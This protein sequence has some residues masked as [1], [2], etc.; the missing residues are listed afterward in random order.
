MENLTAPA[1]PGND[2][3]TNA[4]F[5]AE[6]ELTEKQ[7]SVLGT[8]F[9]SIFIEGP[10]DFIGGIFGFFRRY[11]R[12]YGES[13]RFFKRPSLKVAPFE[14]ND[15]KENAMQSFELALIFTAALIFMIKQSWIPVNNDLQE[16]YGNDIFQLFFELIIFVIFALA[17]FAQIL[18]SVLAGRLLRF[19]F[20]VPVTRRESDVLFCYLNNAF[21]SIAALLAFVFRCGMQYDQIQ[22]TSTESGIMTFCF[23]TSFCLVTWWSVN[24]ARLNRLSVVRKLFF[25]IFSI[26]LFTLLYGL[27]TS[28]ICLF[29]IGA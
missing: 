22:G 11:F 17:Y 19:L 14:K 18:L 5:V 13:F 1:V 7:P 15:F 2:I 23:L 26:L 6:T 4:E 20:S 16:K 9:R 3:V 12:H 21:F 24:F 27:G 8:V 29:I 28:A 10:K 25:Y